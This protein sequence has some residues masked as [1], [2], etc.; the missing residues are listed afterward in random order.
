MIETI[1]PVKIKIIGVGGAGG[2]A[3][4]RMVSSGLIDAK[5]VEFISMNTDVQAL[6]NS[7]AHITIQL[8]VKTTKGQGSGGDPKVGQAAAEES[9]EIVKELLSNTDMV[10]I[11]CGM[12]GG[13]GTGA[14]PVIAK[15]AKSLGVLTVGIV[16][17]PFTKLEGS[18][19]KHNAEIGISELRKN[20]DALLVI[21]N[22]KFLEIYPDVSFFDVLYRFSDDVIYKAVLSIWNVVTKPGHVNVDFA[23]AKSV[24]RDAGD[25]IMSVGSVEED[26]DNKVIKAMKKALN[27]PFIENVSINGAKKILVNICGVDIVAND[28]KMVG[29]FLAQTVSNNAHVFVGYVPDTS[30]GK[31]VEIT[32][33]ASGFSQA[34][35]PKKLARTKKSITTSINEEE[36]T[37]NASNIDI[38]KVP[39]ITRGLRVLK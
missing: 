14:S 13:T 23:D 3:V 20:V 22:D 27:N 24:L 17:K 36:K 1:N 33:I 32:L 34:D 19:R 5:D 16:T 39:A 37:T 28:M 11:T 38:S 9:I 35:K 8:G 7:S 4:N 6:R 30:F 12:G 31:K 2:N 15:V 29:E 21:Q 26:T 18:E 25:I 10:F